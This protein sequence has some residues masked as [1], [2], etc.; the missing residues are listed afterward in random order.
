MAKP[1]V[2]KNNIDAPCS[3]FK[4]LRKM[5]VLLKVRTDMND[6]SL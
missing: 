5:L 1:G 6:I 2:Q 3:K 4:Q